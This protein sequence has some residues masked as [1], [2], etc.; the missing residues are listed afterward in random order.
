MIEVFVEV[1]AGSRDKR[2]YDEQT[3]LYRKTRRVRLPYPF[4]YGFVLG[5]RCDDGGCVDCYI[6]TSD[7]LEAGTVVSCRPVGLLEQ[8]EEEETDHKVLATLPG[9]SADLDRELHEKLSGFIRGVF[10]AFPGTSVH[11]GRILPE[12]T[13]MEYLRQHRVGENGG[14]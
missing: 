4:A 13:A 9:Q 6:L 1:E 12:E 8:W 14:Q 3:L 11:V 10:R 5:T 2:L 7:R